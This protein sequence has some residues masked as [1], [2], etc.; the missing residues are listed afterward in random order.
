VQIP[1]RT[2]L[3]RLCEVSKSLY[4][5][6]IP[7]LYENIGI[8]AEDEQH[9]ESVE[10]EP[11]LRT[12]SKLTSHLGHVRFVQV[13]SRF[14]DLLEERC[15]HYMDMFDV[16]ESDSER[17]P[18]FEKIAASLMLLFERLREE[19]LREF[20]FAINPRHTYLA[21]KLWRGVGRLDLV[22]FG[23]TSARK[24]RDQFLNHFHRLRF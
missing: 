15:L 14:H 22:R 18:R 16:G 20:R 21:A 9:L 7:K 10:V 4:D 6:A 5:A 19:S 8:W 12:S 2:D 11:F 3:K 1:R 24:C 13:R 23:P 17:Q